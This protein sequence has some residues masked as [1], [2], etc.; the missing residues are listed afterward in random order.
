MQALSA[1]ARAPRALPRSRL[2][3]TIASLNA[4]WTGLCRFLTAPRVP[5]TN[6][7][8]ERS[9]HGCVVGRKTDH[10]SK[11]VRST[12]VAALLYTLL[13]SARLAGV[14]PRAYL[15]A[16]AEAALRGDA[17]LLPHVHSEALQ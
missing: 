3:E 8:A 12:E 4:Y 1:W 14:E 11:S 9:L 6:N 10:G 5:R 2:G 17:P 15:R 16:T 13:E 7:P